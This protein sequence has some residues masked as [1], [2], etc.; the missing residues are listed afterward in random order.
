MKNFTFPDTLYL[1]SVL[2]WVK[3][4]S[5][6][7][8]EIFYSLLY[9]DYSIGCLNPWQHI[10][11]RDSLF[12]NRVRYSDQRLRNLTYFFLL[13]SY[14]NHVTSLEKQEKQVLLI[15]HISSRRPTSDQS[16][17][18]SAWQPHGWHDSISV[19]LTYLCP[20]NSIHICIWISYAPMGTT[21]VVPFYITRSNIT[22]NQKNVTI[23]PFNLVRYPYG[24]AS[25]LRYRVNNTLDHYYN[26]SC[27]DIAQPAQTCLAL[28]SEPN[29]G[30]QYWNQFCGFADILD[31]LKSNK[32]LS[33]CLDESSVFYSTT[34]DTEYFPISCF[35][36]DGFRLQRLPE[37]SNIPKYLV[38]VDAI[39][40]RYDS[41][42]P[43]LLSISTHN[44]V[45]ALPKRPY[46]V[47][48]IKGNSPSNGQNTIPASVL[49]QVI[50]E[51]ARYLVSHTGIDLIFDG[52]C[53]PDNPGTQPQNP[54]RQSFVARENLLYDLSV[55]S[56]S[57]DASHIKSIIGSSTSEKVDF[58]ENSQ[59]VISFA[60]SAV[61]LPY[62]LQ[63]LIIDFKPSD[64]FKAMFSSSANRAKDFN[65]ELW[66]LVEIDYTRPASEIISTICM[67]LDSYVNDKKGF[68]SS[69]SFA[70]CL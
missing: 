25:D 12:G 63:K 49:L 10:Y 51:V 62:A 50:P 22:S 59:F 9:P 48:L 23:A 69:H 35:N 33:Y 42:R 6:K 30:H 37:S 31:F 56:L 7:A 45:S 67:H 13:D 16:E 60:N 29:L 24:D 55:R 26:N 27:H 44:A 28:S 21:A 11:I 57:D 2:S 65:N 68:I 34:P 14:Q 20:E 41:M 46:A 18:I 4:Q 32:S 53:S 8:F 66:C 47:F 52:C 54:K 61:F 40:P 64:E 58:Y 43:R 3:N 19:L 38:S 36:E 17:H 15:S 70:A 5:P 39:R 1:S